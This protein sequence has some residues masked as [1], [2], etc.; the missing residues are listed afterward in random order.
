MRYP[1]GKGRCFQHIIS[2]MP[3]HDVY[4]EAFLGGGAVLRS[5]LPAMRSI[6]IEADPAVIAKWTQEEIRGFEIIHGDAVT[7]LSNYQF[8]GNELVYCDPP[9]LQETRRKARI[10]R[11]EYSRKQHE[12][13]LTAL[14]RLPCHVMVSGYRSRMYEER[15]NNWIAVDF[16]GDSHTGPRTE[17]VWL[18]FDPPEVLH[19]YRFIGRTFRDRESIK[20][21]RDAIS[22]RIEALPPIERNAILSH[23][24]ATYSDHNSPNRR[25]TG[26]SD[27]AERSR[28]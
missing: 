14:D 24:A 6:A 13:L 15:L 12:T 18:N 16:P 1:G 2:M 7:F 20:R 10:Y 3:P 27:R 28:Q 23:L 25:P 4:I 19:D 22:K 5:K 9:Y 21:R 8:E 26:M 17:T 11:Y